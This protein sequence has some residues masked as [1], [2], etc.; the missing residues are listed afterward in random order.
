MQYY[1]SNKTLQKGHIC[2]T[3]I[4][5]KKEENKKKRMCQIIELK[6]CLEKKRKEYLKTVLK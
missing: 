2:I 4:F 1:Y 6:I 5:Q 3:E